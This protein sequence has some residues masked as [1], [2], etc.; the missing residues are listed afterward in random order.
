MSLTAREI[1]TACR[2]PLD[3][4]VA[5]WPLVV[6]ALAA[7]GIRSDL[8]EVGIAATLAV[9]TAHTFKPINEYGGDD[10]DAYYTRRYEGR[11]DLGNTQR[12]DGARYHGRGYP[13]LTGRANYRKAGLALGLDLEGQPELALDPVVSANLT[14]WFAKANHIDVAANA[15]DWERVRRRWNGGLNGWDEFQ[16]CVIRLVEVLRG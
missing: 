13:Q 5:N 11:R 4:V 12:G 14:A 6:S 9:E 1:A 7:A 15:Q 16:R 8:A 10:P 3:A 2:C